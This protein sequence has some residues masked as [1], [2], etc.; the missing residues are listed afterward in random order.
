M[1][2]RNVCSGTRPRWYMSTRASSAPPR[3]PAA[4][5]LMPSAPKSLA[6]CNAFFMARR[7]ETRRSSCNAMFSATS[8]ASSSGVFTSTMS[9]YTSLPVLRLSSSLSL[10][11]SAPLRPMTTPG[12]AVRMVTR[13]RLVA[14]SIKILG[15]EAVSSFFLSNSRIWRSS[16]SRAG[17]SFLPAY[18]LERQSLLTATRTPI[19]LVFWP[20]LFVGQS[21]FYVATALEDRT[22]RTA[23]LGLKTFEGGGRTGDRFLDMESFGAQLV[24]VLRVGN[25]GFQ[26]LGHD[27]RAFAGHDGEDSLRLDG[28]HALDLTRDLAH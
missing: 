18:H 14:R 27:A 28:A 19:G 24:V 13:Q 16:V 11:I 1:S 4:R 23:R 2:A 22:G 9:T 21:D 26:G 6:V 8:W 7:N 17:N 3:R 25:G 10:S 12:R 20:I 5:T 15:T